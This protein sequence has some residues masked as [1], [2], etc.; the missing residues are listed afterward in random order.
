MSSTNVHSKKNI[1]VVGGQTCFTENQKEP[2]EIPPRSAGKF[3]KKLQIVE[4]EIAQI[5]VSGNSVLKDGDSIIGRYTE[6]GQILSGN[7]K[8]VRKYLN[9]NEGMEK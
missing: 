4:G 9:H 8:N 1:E 5:P 3:S 2:V 6:D 7:A